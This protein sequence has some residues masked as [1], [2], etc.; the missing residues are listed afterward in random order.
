[1]L[2]E[3]EQQYK[4]AL[5]AARAA[6]K[7]LQDE[8]RELR[9]KPRELPGSRHEAPGG[10]VAVTGMSCLF[11]GVYPQDAS[12]ADDFYRQLLAGTDSVIPVPEERRRIWGQAASGTGSATAS[13]TGSGTG[14]ATDATGDMAGDM[15]G[16]MAA[17]GSNL[18]KYGSFLGRDIFAFDSAF[19]Q[20]PPAEARMTDPQHRLLLELVWQAFMDAGIDPAKTAGSGTGVFAG[21]TSTDFSF[22]LLGCGP[23]SADDPYTMTGNMHSALA[24]RISYF[25][26]WT[27]PCVSCET[28]CSTGLVA[29]MNAVSSLRNGECALA[30][31][32]AVNLM[33]GPTPSRWLNAMHA[34]APD[35]RCKAFGAGADGFGRGEGGGVLLLKRLADAQK[36]GDRIH[37]VILGGAIG[38]DGRSRSFSAPSAKGQREVIRRALED[39]GVKPE[40]VGY[41][42]THGTGTPL[43][44]PIEAESLAAVY[45]KRNSSLYIGSVK[46]N[47]GHLESAAG[48][49]GLIKAIGALKGGVIPKTLHAAPSNPLLDWQAL[50][51]A[52]ALENTPWPAKLYGPA[53][54]S[55]NLP[56]NPSGQEGRRVA[57]VSSFAIAGTLAHLIL[58]Q[59]P[60]QEGS[61][62]AEQAAQN[63]VTGQIAAARETGSLDIASSEGVPAEAPA[64]QCLVLPLSALNAE[65]LAVQ[66]EGCVTMLEG[67]VSWAALCSAASNARPHQAALFPERLAIC[68]ANSPAC[69]PT[70]SPEAL[71]VFSAFTSGK[72][73]RALLRGKASK[74][75]PALFVFSGQGSQLGGMGRDLYRA[76]PEFRAVLDR[77]EAL[78]AP[79]LGHSLLEVMFA[80]NDPRLNETR[81]TQPAIYSHQA[82][83]VELLRARG[84]LPGAVLGHSIGEYAAAFAAG[85]F[86]LEDG[87]GI[88]LKRGALAAAIA[89]PG[90]M[91]AVLCSQATAAGLLAPCA[92]VSVAAVNGPD[93][94]TISGPEA[95]VAAALRL[96][97]ENG[98]ESRPMPVSHAF[99]CALIEPALPPFAEYLRGVNFAAPR[100]PF[101]SC[102]TG[103][104]LEG[105]IDWAEYFVGQTRQPVLFY[106]ALAGAKEDVFLEIG[107]GPTLTSYGRQFRSE[108]TWLFT[109]NGP[110]GERPLARALA[111]LH[112]L[113]H[114]LNW[115]WQRGAAW[116]P[117]KAPLTAF[118][119]QHL[120]PP[121]LQSILPPI[122]PQAQEKTA[123]GGTKSGP[124]D[125]MEIGPK[126]QALP[127]VVSALAQ[128]E[129]VE[130]DAPGKPI[131]DVS[132]I[133]VNSGGN[134]EA[135]PSLDSLFELA[136]LQCETFG[137]VC[138]AQN[139]Y[140]SKIK[141]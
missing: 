9:E 62:P 129:A 92:Q 90:A 112:V 109:Q 99:H 138:A 94:V 68:A 102:R 76:F 38:S 64:P 88:T 4:D 15:A 44:D 81:V 139:E 70:D 104:L 74:A 125:S 12:T 30:V 50:R 18:I 58:A 46:S 86:S 25:F 63:G 118:R 100:V 115:G 89:E 5:R 103:A 1:M 61:G 37:A 55:A 21:K 98:V 135:A 11:P 126:G 54:L 20:I 108:G 45:G 95:A 65:T 141:S 78:A 106:Q 48:M 23:Q 132:A 96:L 7:E 121:A 101:I 116:L 85:V 47:V 120:A 19:F 87:L 140:L 93:T 13:G 41:I 34:L 14:S 8:M 56:A 66:A 27:G 113:G 40:D 75:S 53:K 29:V 134:K 39:A 57:G 111:G 71:K 69:P 77:C 49:A 131:V 133:N 22:D 16:G 67:G 119:Q 122:L 36:D 82:A 110:E 79:L 130:E 84:A 31:A 42:E 117:E 127:P 33:L 28:A 114:E 10:A 107:A 124:R 52:P 2:A 123:E 97:R 24:G 91:A 43:G 136:R 32:G 3:K 35:G 128:R 17:S 105:G 60:E 72:A 83:L 59:A 51:L 26:D 6:I 80:E 137:R 73:N